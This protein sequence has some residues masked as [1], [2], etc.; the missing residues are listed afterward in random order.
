MLCI[1]CCGFVSKNISNYYLIYCYLCSPYLYLLRNKSTS[2]LAIIAFTVSPQTGQGWR[3]HQRPTPN[4]QSPT[5]N[6]QRQH[7][8]NNERDNDFMVI[9]VAALF[10]CT[11]FLSLNNPRNMPAPSTDSAATRL[12]FLHI[13]PYPFEKCRRVSLLML[14]R[15][16]FTFAL[17][18]DFSK[19]IQKLS[20]DSPQ[21]TA[22]FLIYPLGQQIALALACLRSSHISANTSSLFICNLQNIC[23]APNSFNKYAEVAAGRF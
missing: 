1:L 11:S 6:A 8:S 9:R 23:L 17:S 14:S 3:Y 21:I 2:L 19:L 22:L 10:H 15:S 12:R 16:Q 5:P 4:A 13:I 7:A 18:P 20:K